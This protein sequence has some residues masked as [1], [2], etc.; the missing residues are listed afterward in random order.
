MVLPILRY[1]V[2]VLALAVPAVAA[3]LPPGDAQAGRIKAESERCN[4][5]HGAQGQGDGHPGT[6]VRFAKLA[7]QHA[8]YLLAQLKHYRS[9]QRRHEVMKLNTRD[10]ADEDLHDLAAYYAT[11]PPM[12]GEP[13]KDD[14]DATPTLYTQGDA[15]RG[16]IACSVCHGP[17]GRGAT[18]LQPQV[19]LLAGQDL[20]YLELQLQDWR[21]GWRTDPTSSVMNQTARQL[22]DAEIKS[23]AVYLASRS[24]R[25]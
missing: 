7:G 10:L 21:S 8:P 25:P 24:A 3:S 18:P 13:A 20:R 1:A 12:R 16:I 23:L 5:C 6:E 17:E 2:A 11:L 9:G 19:P 4:E 22:T 14:H 15:R